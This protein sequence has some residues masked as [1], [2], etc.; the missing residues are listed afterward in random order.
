M[1]DSTFAFLCEI[2]LFSMFFSIFSIPFSHNL[3]YTE[4]NVPNP[5]RRFL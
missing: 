3:C 5:E 2:K 1:L 4:A